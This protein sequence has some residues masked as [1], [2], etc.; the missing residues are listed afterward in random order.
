MA[1]TKGNRREKDVEEVFSGITRQIRAAEKRAADEDPWTLEN[2]DAIIAAAEAAKLRT[3][4]RLR[5]VG[6]TWTDI[7][8]NQGMSPAAC[9]NKY[10]PL[11]KNL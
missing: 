10:A 1:V 7:A 2:F 9:C 3:I 6:Y 8:Y 11:I 5:D 4:K